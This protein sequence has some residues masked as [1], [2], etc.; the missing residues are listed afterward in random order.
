MY[1]N[2]YINI[3]KIRKGHWALLVVACLCFITISC[4]EEKF[5]ETEPIDFYSPT[6]SYVTS[7]DYEAAVLR[8][9]KLVRD[10]FFSSDGQYDFPSAG[11]QATDLFHLHKNIGFNSDMS[12]VLFPTND[13]MV[14]EALWKPAYQIIFDANAII[15]RANSEDNELTTEEKAIFTGEAKFFRGYYYK[16]LANLY[17]GVP[18]VLEETKS[19]IRDFT[20]ASR[21]AVYQQAAS[22]LKDAADNLGEIDVV[23]DHRLNRLAALHLLSEV[24]ISLGQWQNAVDAASTV[25]IGRAHV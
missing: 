9:Y 7:A 4:D 11:M 19:P 25:K 6:N 5:L 15:E 8:I 22:D 14:Y 12:S 1:S 16:M 23:P 24:Y 17:G 20:N 2:K 3:I 13:D 10:G 21:E 18:I